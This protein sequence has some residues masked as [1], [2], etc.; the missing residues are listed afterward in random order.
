MFPLSEAW[1]WR[2]A[3]FLW[4]P[5]SVV[6]SKFTQWVSINFD[7]LSKWNLKFISNLFHE[8]I[9]SYFNLSMNGIYIFFFYCFY[10]FWIKNKTS[11]L[12]KQEIEEKSS[13]DT[14]EYFSIWSNTK[15]LTELFCQIK[16]L[17]YTILA[18]AHSLFYLVIEIL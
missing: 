4:I 1:K 17:A 12:C 3:Q 7:I 10:K 16:I 11:S 9:F 14:K 18:W 5:R 2:H 6:K 13:S 15:Q 8:L